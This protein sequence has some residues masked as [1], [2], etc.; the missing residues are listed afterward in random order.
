LSRRNGQRTQFRQFRRTAYL[1]G[2]LLE[3]RQQLLE[4]M[5]A[6]FTATEDATRRD[7][8]DMGNMANDRLARDTTCEIGSVESR[9]LNDIDHALQRIEAD[10]YGV[11][12]DCG[13]RIAAARLRVVP[14]VTLCVDC[15]AR[16]EN[17]GGESG[18]D[19]FSW[20]ETKS[21]A[22]GDDAEQ[23]LVGAYDKARRPG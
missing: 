13:R 12:E 19:A 20:Q 7:P 9:A 11:C 14:F 8:G 2:K 15:K 10:A 5:V 23:S 1:R 18:E 6:G 22:S 3:N 17:E 21:A 4:H 16:E